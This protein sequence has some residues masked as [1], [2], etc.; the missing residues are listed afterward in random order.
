MNEN[1][2]YFTTRGLTVGYDGKPLIR[3]ITVALRRG[4]ILTLIGPNGSGKSTI[5]KSITGQLRL[6]GGV[7][8]L[9][10]QPTAGMSGRELSQKLAVVLTAR[11]KTELM[12][13]AD[14]VATGRYPYTGH[15][16]ILSPEDTAIVRAAMEQ[17]DVWALRD[18]DYT[19]V[20]DGQRQRVM[21]AR[22]VCQQPEIIV[23][24]EP[25]SFLDI[26]Y[27]LE[28]LRMLKDMARRQNIAVL[29]SLHELDLAQKLSDSVL[30]VKGETVA[31]Y[32][33][34]EEI[35][36]PERIRALYDLERGSY[37]P[38]FGSVELSAPA[39]AAKLF[40]LA[41]GGSGIRVY[42]ALQKREV[43]FING[44]LHENDIDCHLA[45][46][47]A[48]G[49]ITT[50]AFEPITENA[51]QVALAALRGCDTVCNCLKGYGSA[52]ARNRDLLAAARTMGL[53]IVEA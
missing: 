6:L 17:A 11:L 9:D 52:N 3:D 22:A 44:I 39:G 40:V 15:L 16:G 25:T 14:V 43:P 5:L 18:R 31:G 36:T 32:G 37:D 41:G 7:V 8:C 27:Q 13:C 53:K 33:P 34:P 24:D 46:A 51:Y 2:F 20:S 45:R 26:R 35:F 23:L 38:V 10:G 29:L 19:C 21:L 47:L 30:C 49:V 42:R 50:P 1:A 28:L 48:G 12:T 4:E